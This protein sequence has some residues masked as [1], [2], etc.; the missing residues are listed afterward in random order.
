MN[1]LTAVVVIAHIAAAFAQSQ[2]LSSQ[3]YSFG[4]GHVYPQETRTASTGHRLHWSKAQSIDP[5]GVRLLTVS[6]SVL[7]SKEAPEWEATA[8]INGEFKELKLSQF[9]GKYVVFFFYP[10][11]L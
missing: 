5:I 6:L 2:D 7:V 4:G 8:V 3:C 11:D 9:R 1:R 10:L